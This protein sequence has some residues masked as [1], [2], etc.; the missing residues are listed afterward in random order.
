[1]ICA[2]TALAVGLPTALARNRETKRLNAELLA[3]Q[4]HIRDSHSRTAMLQ[5]E[6]VRVHDAIRANL[7]EATP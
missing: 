7:K 6:I 5:R 2:T 1:V 4:G 3:L